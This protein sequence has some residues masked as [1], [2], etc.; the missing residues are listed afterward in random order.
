MVQDAVPRV[1]LGDRSWMPRVGLG[2][3]P[4]DD[5]AAERIVS[6]AAELGYRHFDTATKYGNER[7]VGAGI[8]DSGLPRDEVFVTTK[9][10]G[11]FQGAGRATAGLEAALERMEME[12]VDLLLIHWPLPGRDEYVSTWNTFETLFHSGLARSIGVSNFTPAHLRRLIAETTVVPAVNQI[13]LNPQIP[14]QEERRFHAS[15]GI[16]TESWSPLGSGKGLLDSEEL[17]V[18]ARVQERTPAQVVLRWHLQHGLVPIPRS[19]D[20]GRLRSNLE[21]FDFELTAQQMQT[22]DGLAVPGAGVDPDVD[23]H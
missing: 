9:L 22:I 8:C 3:W 12:Y 13:Q 4:M 17:A 16:V 14:R 1:R 11:D 23:G 6:A 21:V 5:A 15:A 2:T 7:G 19:T 20:T 18:I 10:N